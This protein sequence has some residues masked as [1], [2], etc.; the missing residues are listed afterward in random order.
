MEPIRDLHSARIRLWAAIKPLPKGARRGAPILREWGAWVVR[1][2][3]GW[4]RIRYVT[5]P[6]HATRSIPADNQDAAVDWAI[7]RIGVG[8]S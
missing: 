5:P 7:E 6:L 4:R 3:R 8:K 1:P 2:G